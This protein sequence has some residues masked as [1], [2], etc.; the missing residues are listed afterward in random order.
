MAFNKLM[1]LSKRNASLKPLLILLYLLVVA[2]LI[3]L[4]VSEH[5][6]DKP[7]FSLSHASAEKE[8]TPAVVSIYGAGFHSDI[9]VVMAENLVNEE[10]LIWQQLDGISAKAIDVKNDLALVACY[11][12]K[13]VSIDLHGGKNP[14][15]LGSLDLPGS[16][17][18]IKIVGDQALVGMQRHEGFYLIDLKDPKALKLGRHI[19]GSGLVSSMVAD[20]NI[21]YLTDV[22][23]GVGR[24][25]LSVKNPVLEIL[26]S[27]ESPWRIALQGNRLAVGTL[28]GRVYLF[29]I[30]QDGQL[31]ETGSLDFPANVR[32]IAFV[33]ETLAVTVADDKLHLFN[34]SSWPVL[35]NPTQLTLPGNPLLLERI[36]GQAS[37]AV[38]LIASGM[39]LIDVAQPT[40]PVLSGELRKPKTFIGMKLQPE[41]F[42]ESVRMD[43]RCSP[44]IKSLGVNTRCWQQRP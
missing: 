41:S 40:A 12:K 34:L 2:L 38:S 31:L 44:S 27:I 22:F 37:L 26:A 20:R 15:I 36:P 17:R 24:I 9:R 19:S 8:Q 25:D 18:Q 21:V 29:E 16:V 4:L 7:P 39:A 11:E 43:W 3:A 42:L 6:G 35:N 33:D 1:A 10:A 14:K 32:G 30:I 13:I 5:Q 23:Q 28:K